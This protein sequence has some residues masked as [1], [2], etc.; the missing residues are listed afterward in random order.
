M[1]PMRNKKDRLE[2]VPA[3]ARRP[4]Q[5][6]WLE[7]VDEAAQFALDLKPGVRPE[8]AERASR[9]SIANSVDPSP[10]EIR[11]EETG[12]HAGIGVPTRE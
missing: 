8:I 5:F 6:R 3:S 7:H 11:S 1:L 9:L 4:L 2:D 12:R 10:W